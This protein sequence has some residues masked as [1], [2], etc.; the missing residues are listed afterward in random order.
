M[1]ETPLYPRLRHL[2]NWAPLI[3]W[4]VL[5]FVFSSDLF[6]DAHT[7]G[8][9]SPWLHWQFPNWSSSEIARAHLL[10]RKLG[11]VSEY[12]IFGL[13]LVRALDGETRRK[14]DYRH[15]LTGIGLTALYAMSDEFH[16]VFV[17]SRSPSAYDVLIDL[18]GGLA[19]A[20]SYYYLIHRG[21]TGTVAPSNKNLDNRGVNRDHRKN[22]KN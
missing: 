14:P 8:F 2:A 1:P 6:S 13:L 16:Q 7:S 5:I 4:A 12:F 10:I 20:L 19:G 22:W 21:T 9:I 15:L 17:P 3:L 11:H 18:C